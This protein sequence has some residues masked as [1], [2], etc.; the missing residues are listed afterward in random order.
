MHLAFIVYQ[1]LTLLDLVG[2]Y[3]PITRLRSMKYLPDLT[4]DFCTYY[5]YPTDNNGFPVKV[6]Q[7]KPDLSGYDLIFVPGGFGSRSLSNDAAFVSWLKTAAPVPTKVSVC[8]GALLLGS[9]GFLQSKKATTH[10]DEYET[11]AAYGAKVIKTE[12]VVEDQGCITGG[13]VASS[14]ELG[15]YLCAKLAGAEAR[16]AIRQ[17]MGL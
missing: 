14:I 4:W 7:R 1:D 5:D 13:A 11:L 16:S 2:F 10:F 9:A 17:R 3:D 15:L 8:T 12:V 6:D